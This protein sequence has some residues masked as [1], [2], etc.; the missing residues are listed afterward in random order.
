MTRTLV[1]LAAVGGLLAV[2]AA[3]CAPAPASSTTAVQR[4]TITIAAGDQA[5]L[6]ANFAL[7]PGVPVVV[8]FRNET[9][10]FHTFT[11]PGL[12]V[13]VLIRPAQGALPRVTTARF[14]LPDYGVYTWRCVLCASG[15][16]QH[17]H[18]MS[19]KLYSIV[20]GP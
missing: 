14:V 3:L 18:A 4:I 19:G 8:T 10:L 20:T 16:H 6:P 15:A 9:H 13:S 12:G 1:F 2:A 7:R 17:M 11:I 5:A